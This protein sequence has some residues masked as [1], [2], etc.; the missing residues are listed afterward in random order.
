MLW[1]NLAPGARIDRR[2]FWMTP[3]C[4]CVC[5]GRGVP[6]TLPLMEFPSLLVLTRIPWAYLILC[7]CGSCCVDRGGGGRGAGGTEVVVVTPHKS[8][9][10]SKILAAASW[11]ACVCVCVWVTLAFPGSPYSLPLSLSFLLWRQAPHPPT[12]PAATPRLCFSLSFE[13]FVHSSKKKIYTKVLIPALHCQKKN[14]IK[15]NDVIVHFFPFFSGCSCLPFDI[16]TC[17]LKSYD[18]FF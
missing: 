7:Q 3:R 14:K 5:V 2:G 6:W 8:F 15:A 1:R 9:L 10:R 13:L 12:C 4:V 16:S 18:Y 11:L 17:I